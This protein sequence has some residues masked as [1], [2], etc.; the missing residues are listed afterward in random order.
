MCTETLKIKQIN[1][2]KRW[3]HKSGL[4]KWTIKVTSRK[5]PKVSRL[6]RFMT[7][8]DASWPISRFW[9]FSFKKVENGAKSC[10]TINWKRVAQNLYKS[11]VGLASFRFSSSEASSILENRMSFFT[12]RPISYLKIWKIS[13]CVIGLFWTAF[14]LVP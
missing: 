3:I 14:T 7:E 13:K 10:Y 12:V 6:S 8:E 1:I 2:N 11:G 5:E 4:N 9:D